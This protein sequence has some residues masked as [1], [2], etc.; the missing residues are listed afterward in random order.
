MKTINQIAKITL[1]KIYGTDSSF[2]AVNFYDYSYDL[3]RVLSLFDTRTLAEVEAEEANFPFP[4]EFPED[5][6][7][8]DL[9]PDSIDELYVWGIRLGEREIP[10]YSGSKSIIDRIVEEEEKTCWIENGYHFTHLVIER[11]VAIEN[12]YPVWEADIYRISEAQWKE[13]VN[14]IHGF[15]IL[16]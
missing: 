15:E 11:R 12:C 1:S 10:M 9:D 4:V 8:R 16:T 13:I 14:K 3:N 6:E 5:G 2:R 7:I